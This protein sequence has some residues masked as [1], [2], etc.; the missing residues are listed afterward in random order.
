M[1]QYFNVELILLEFKALQIDL[2][3]IQFKNQKISGHAE[4]LLKKQLL[5]NKIIKCF[6]NKKSFK[7]Q[8][9]KKRTV[10]E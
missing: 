7:Y 8:M 9:L 4:F 2:N 5:R 1:K 6:K 3:I 10:E